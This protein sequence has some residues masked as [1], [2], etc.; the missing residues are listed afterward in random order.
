MVAVSTPEP[1]GGDDNKCKKSK[2]KDEGHEDCEH[3]A[4]LNLP[5]SLWSLME[6]AFCCGGK[7][8]GCQQHWRTATFSIGRVH[9]QH[10][11]AA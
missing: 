3:R 9:N 10:E 5:G 2:P 8:G 11:L 6:E 7:S 1:D 4:K